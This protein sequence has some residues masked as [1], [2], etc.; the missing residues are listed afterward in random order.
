MTKEQLKDQCDAEFENIQSVLIELSAVV[1]SEKTAYSTKHSQRSNPP[2]FNI[3][4][5]QND[6]K[7]S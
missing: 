1:R 7:K 5:N 4:R 2:S 3:L 6:F